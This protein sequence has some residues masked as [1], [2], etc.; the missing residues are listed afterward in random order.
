MTE[1][2]VCDTHNMVAKTIN[3]EVQLH[4]QVDGKKIVI[5]KGTVRR[6]LQLEDAEGIDCLPNSTIFKQLALMG[7]KTTAWNE[8]S[9]TMAS[10]II[11]LATN[12][13]FNF[14]KYIFESMMK[15]L[16][17][18]SS[19]FLMC[20]RFVQVFLEKQLDEM[21]AHKRIYIAPSRTKKIL[22]NM[23]RV[24][25]G[26]SGRV[27]PLFPTMMVQAQ[28]E[29][30]EGSKIPTNPHHTPTIIQPSTSQ[31]QNKQKPR[32]P[33]RKDTKIPQSSVPSDN[34]ADEAVNEEMDDS[35]VRA[36]TT[37]S[38]LEEEQ[39]SGN[40]NKTQSKAT[41]NESSS[42]GT[43][44]G[45]GPRCQ[46]TIGDTIAQTRFENVS[47]LSN[48]PLL[49]RG[50]TLRSGEDSLKLQ[51]L[52]ELC[53]NLQQRVLDLEKTKTTQAE[54]IVSL[55]RRVKKLEQKKRSRTHGL[56]KLYKVGSS[57]RVESSDE[58]G[59]GEEDASKQ[60]RIAD[61][62][63]NKDNYL[64]N[65]HTDEDMF[66]VNDLDGDE[67]IVESVDV[68][69]TA[70]EIVNVAATT[71]ST[72]STIP[73]SAATTTT[74]TTVITD[75]EITLAQALAEL[76]S[77]KPKAK[78]IVIHEQE[79]APTPTVSSQQPL[80]VKVQ[81]KGKGKMVE[82]E[83]VKKLSKNDQLRLDEELAF[84]L[85][86]EEEE[87]ERLAKEK[88]QQMEEASIAW[89]NVQAKIEANYQLAQRLQAQEQE[90]LIDEEKTRLF[91]QFLE[92]RR[93][94]F[95]AKRVEEKRNRPPTR[96]QQRS[97]MCTYLK[98][99]KGWKPK[100]LKNKSF[101]NIQELFDKAMKRVNTFIDY[102]NKLMEESSKKA[103][104]E[105]EENSKR[106]S[107]R[108]Q[109][110]ESRRRAGT[111]KLE[112]DAIPLATKPPTI[113]DWKIHKEG[114]NSYYQ[115]IR[116]DGSSKMYRVFSQMLK[117]FDMEDLETLYKLVKAKYGSTRPVEDLDLIL[118]GDLK[119][120]SAH[121]DISFAWGEMSLPYTL[122]LLTDMLNKK[123]QCDHFSEMG[124]IIGI[125]RLLDDLRVTAVKLM[126]LVYKLLLLVLKVNAASTKVTTA[127][128]LRL[129]KE[130]LLS[131]KG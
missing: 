64:V 35:L 20:P 42:P 45:G 16:D 125:K 71:V 51:E 62:D 30:G 32:K 130:F 92:Q 97:I 65:V 88:A 123:L 99:M 14:S 121:V 116:A 84:K 78:G 36:A 63:V 40:I 91:V 9:S 128:R 72:A 1:P 44:S 57:R 79:Q 43:T 80:Q 38:S 70:E 95:A 73:V 2:K 48:D 77:T 126:L 124:R 58:E 18:L 131:E 53:T 90:E 96:A 122:L 29:M 25:I 47:K 6:D 111:R 94:H 98:N 11:C 5:T 117:S 127:Q 17:N 31:P 37:A 81:D 8:F 115:I 22:K 13:K 68:V 56:K 105:L 118:Y 129:L 50:N 60:G 67:V 110:K 107:T 83:P 28:E 27:T 46:E 74:T 10:A 75:V 108:E 54:E 66:G 87:E 4:A 112:I 12:K 103:E 49:E 33:K 69:K 61:I 19:K 41:P 101:A 106:D 102:K 113:V 15:N 76:K 24:G 114:K 109:F 59:L 119:T 89:D 104:T 52:M 26:F 93:K 82:P 21:S 85:Q 86:A 7:E 120:V 23:R 34:V 3:G 39:D 100:N 55:K